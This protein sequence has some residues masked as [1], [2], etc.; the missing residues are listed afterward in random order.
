MT[1]LKHHFETGAVYCVTSV[2]RGRE[3]I[4][5]DT[6]AC[7]FFITCLEYQKQVLGFRLYGFVVMPDHFHC[8]LQPLNGFDLPKVMNC[9]KGNFARKFNVMRHCSGV[10]W[11][12]S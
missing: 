4:F 9:L 3:G 6:A 2:T 10:L 5:H 7:R 12:K 1:N 8:V 11:Q